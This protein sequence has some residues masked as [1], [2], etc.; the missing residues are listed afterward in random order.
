MYNGNRNIKNKEFK[1]KESDER[2]KL[3]EYIRLYNLENILPESSIDILQL[4][5]FDTDQLIVEES[6]PVNYLHILVKGKCR[7]SPTSEEGKIAL[8]DFILPKDVIGDIEFFSKD[9]YYHNVRTILPCVTL[10]IPVKFIDKYFGL[11]VDFYK[12]ICENMASKMKSTSLKYSKT[13]LYPIK[14]QIASYFYDE[15]VKNEQR[16]LPIIFKELSAF[17]GITPRYF[18]NILTELESEG[19]L[20]RETNGVKLLDPEKLCQY[21]TNKK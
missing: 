16:V 9:Q 15:F 7:V 10:S 4:N 18:R 12:F 21:T 1:M 11:N 6:T 19:I 20:L 5:Y 17:F 3:K 13:L 14:N 2:K 8:L